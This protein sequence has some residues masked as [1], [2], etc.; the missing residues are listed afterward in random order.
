MS[1]ISYELALGMALALEA[2]DT[3]LNHLRGL[4]DDAG[5]AEPR[6]LAASLLERARRR[7]DTVRNALGDA[8]GPEAPQGRLQ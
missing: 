1:R 7:M 3:D 8:C 4:I 5:A 6:D 2:A